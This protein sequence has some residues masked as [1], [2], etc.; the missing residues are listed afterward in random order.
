M[1][2][3]LHVYEQIHKI[4]IE[5]SLCSYIISSVYY[6]NIYIVEKKKNLNIVVGE[7]KMTAFLMY[8]Y[9]TLSANVSKHSSI[10]IV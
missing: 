5:S 9:N 6:M 8:T 7:N 4:V 3:F 10:K 1:L 2:E